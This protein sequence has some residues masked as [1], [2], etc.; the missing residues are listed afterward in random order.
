MDGEEKNNHLELSE[1]VPLPKQDQSSNS[2]TSKLLHDSLKSPSLYKE[3]NVDLLEQISDK[4][5]FG[6]HA[7]SDVAE[8]NENLNK[9]HENNSSLK[10]MLPLKLPQCLLSN[11]NVSEEAFSLPPQDMEHSHS[12]NPDNNRTENICDTEKCF[13]KAKEE[14]SETV[15]KMNE[16]VSPDDIPDAIAVFYGERDE[17]ANTGKAEDDL[18]VDQS[19]GNNSL[20]DTTVT[21]NQKDHVDSCLD[22]VSPTALVLPGKG[23]EM[24]EDSAPNSSDAVSCVLNKDIDEAMEINSGVHCEGDDGSALQGS[25]EVN[26][27]ACYSDMNAHDKPLSLKESPALTGEDKGLCSEGERGETNSTDLLSKDVDNEQAKRKL[28]P[29][30]AS[31]ISPEKMTVDCKSLEDDMHSV[32]RQLSPSCLLPQVKLKAVETDPNTEKPNKVN[33]KQDAKDNLHISDKEIVN[34]L[35][36]D[37]TSS[38]SGNSVTKE[39]IERLETLIPVHEQPGSHRNLETKITPDHSPVAAQTPELV[40]HVLSEMGPPLPPVLTPLK[41]P[42]K[43]GKPINPKHA[44][45]KLS[46]PSPMDSSDSPTTPVKFHSTPNSQLLTSPIHPN[47]APSSPLQFGSATPKHALP[48]P[49][50]LPTKP[51]NSS[52]SASPPQ[53]NS[54]RIL[55]SMY[56]QMSARAWTLNILK[57]NVNL[58]TCS[59]ENGSLPKTTDGQISGFK[60]ISS[61]ST[62]FT[63]TETRGEKRHAMNLSQ[64]KISKCPK[65]EGSS[66][67]VTGERESSFSLNDGDEA[68]SSS[69]QETV[70]N[71][72]NTASP[73][74]ESGEP[75]EQDLIVNCLNKIKNQ[76]FDLLPVVQSH[77]FVGNL[78]KKPVLR[79]EEKEVISEICRCSE[80]SISICC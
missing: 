22:T 10:N 16:D 51:I 70:M 36:S 39:Q 71:K 74:I 8:Q 20:E 35:E 15:T 7:L 4:K 9:A 26:V 61:S 12:E 3:E 53:E 1:D 31:S 24:P 60:T 75:A 59:S 14:S 27:T 63:K 50:R 44:I 64:P 79:D 18:C 34:T 30:R 28:T 48:V 76:C 23:S 77:L 56:P 37:Q 11:D 40:G 19:E 72:I 67:C 57:G 47:G 29:D 41:T 55:G 42:P 65:L 2:K 69:T 33:T 80:V 32:C 13:E 46:F 43:A 66:T 58:G 45:G 54:M 68:A 78:P 5:N 49:G 38:P 21:E 25:R 52:P 62:A 73:S 6:H 17:I